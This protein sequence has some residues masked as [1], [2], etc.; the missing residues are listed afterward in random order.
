MTIVNLDPREY[1]VQEGDTITLSNHGLK[2]IVK[3]ISRDWGTLYLQ[4]VLGKR[5]GVEL[6][7]SVRTIERDTTRPQEVDW[8]EFYDDS[9]EDDETF[10][11]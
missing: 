8:T 2:W 3:R 4:S 10:K 1:S 5:F 11:R 9:E 7:N 6:N